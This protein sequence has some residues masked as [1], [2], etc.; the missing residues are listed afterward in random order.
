[1]SCPPLLPVEVWIDSKKHS[2]YIQTTRKLCSQ[3]PL[4]LTKL[5][6]RI[7]FFTDAEAKD[8]AY[9][10]QKRNVFARHSWENSFYVSRALN[11]A[12]RT[13]I[14]VR[15]LRNPDLIIAECQKVVDIIQNIAL[16]SS[17]FTLDRKRFQHL[18]GIEP[19]LG[20]EFSIAIGKNY[21]YLRS[22]S[23]STPV[24]KGISID[25]RFRKRFFR[26]G[27]HELAYFCMSSGKL[28]NRVISAIR[29][30][31]ESREEPLLPAA[32]VK[33][34]IALESL[35][36]FG[37]SEP[38]AKSLSERVAFLLS[39]EAITREQIGHL[40]KS[41]YN[42]RSRTVHGTKTSTSYRL[43]EV[44]DRMIILICLIVAVNSEKWKSEVDLHK[45]C[46][47]IKWGKKS[48]LRFPF[49]NLYL[50]NA[51]KLSNKH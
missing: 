42:E 24:V 26:C 7:H 49:P 12:N 2:R 43:L 28:A 8:L 37:K 17:T 27:F 14:E 23:K 11:L 40:V 31:V 34:S 33:S 51:I 18:L 29:W 9:F 44:I 25:E 15:R 19:Y 47:N 46:D 30:L 16:L 32:I 10:I 22:K 5:D 48:D 35:L 6:A 45:W 38:L 13:V 21:Q 36:G 1:M 50:K 41:F 20:D 3:T 4:K 39:S